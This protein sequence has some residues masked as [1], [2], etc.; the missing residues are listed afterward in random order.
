MKN[1]ITNFVLNTLHKKIQS[2]FR[3]NEEGRIIRKTRMKKFK[4]K[5]KKLV[6]AIQFVAVWYLLILTGSYLTTDTGAY[7]NDVEVIEEKLGA[8]DD[9]DRNEVGEE[10]DRSSLSFSNFGGFC[11]K[12]YPGIIFSEI[13]NGGDQDMAGTTKYYLY[14]VD[15]GE[16]GPNKN[17]LG[18]LIASGDVP[19]LQGENSSQ[20][21]AI[22][23]FKPNLNEIKPGKYKFKADQRPN[24]G[25]PNNDP[26]KEKDH[27]TWGPE[28]TV[29]END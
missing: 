8:A 5:G 25:N 14:R 15:I 27:E 9:F 17:N 22:L 4:P 24:H 2:I 7:F 21:K 29:T 3:T 19:I 23:T 1:K 13:V 26:N 12:D 11:S 6:L 28:I 10:W 18:E 20:N 16:D